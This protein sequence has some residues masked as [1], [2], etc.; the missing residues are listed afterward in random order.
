[1]Q[2][3]PTLYLL[4][5]RLFTGW[6][7]LIASLQ[8]LAGGW[9]D[10]PPKLAVIVG[11]WLHEGKPY[12]FFEPVLRKVVL[13]LPLFT[14]YLVTFS[15]LLIGAALLAGLFTRLASLWGLVMVTLYLLGRGDGAGP[16]PTAPFVAILITLALT[17]TGRVLGLDAALSD[18]V[19]RWLT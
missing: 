15:E 10:R 14:T 5:L 6:V 1:M 12:G 17:H 4:P 19:P 3:T 9:L 7:F 11:G 13:N 2:D 8:K 18:K 16:N